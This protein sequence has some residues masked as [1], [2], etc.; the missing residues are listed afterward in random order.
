MDYKNWYIVHGLFHGDFK[1][2]INYK[3]KQMEINSYDPKSRKL[4]LKEGGD[5]ITIILDSKKSKK[6]S[7]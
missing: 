1:N 6:S 4:G 7:V 3:Y 5:I 2:D